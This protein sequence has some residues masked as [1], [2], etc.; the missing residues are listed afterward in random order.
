MSCFSH[1]SCYYSYSN[2]AISL[3]FLKV[4]LAKGANRERPTL[5]APQACVESFFRLTYR[6]ISATSTRF[7]PSPSVKATPSKFSVATTSSVRARWC[8]STD[9]V[10]A[11]T[12]TKLSRKRSTD[13]R[14][15]SPSTLQTAKSV[16]LSLT[17]TA[18]NCSPTRESNNRKNTKL[19]GWSSWSDTATNSVLYQQELWKTASNS[20]VAGCH[21]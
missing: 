20:R 7:A 8:Q 10:S 19:R 6:R 21:H 15:R 12:S 18:R 11:S 14:L 2:D 1:F 17:R 16:P 4:Y 13:N 5:P 9:A 3:S